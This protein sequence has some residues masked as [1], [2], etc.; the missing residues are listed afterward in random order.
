MSDKKQQMTPAERSLRARYA[1]H[2]KWS[3]IADPEERRKATAAARAKSP[4]TFEYWLNVAAEQ[5]P[6][7]SGEALA[8]VAKSLHSKEM[9]RRALKSAAT[10]K[11]KKPGAEAA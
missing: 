2:T 5:H 8:A 3:S 10:R 6:H 4:V 7:L 9:S 11:A 1:A